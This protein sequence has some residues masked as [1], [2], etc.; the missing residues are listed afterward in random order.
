M[1]TPIGGSGEGGAE[2]PAGPIRVRW[3]ACPDTAGRPGH[4]QGRPSPQHTR[5]M[6]RQRRVAAP[7]ERSAGATIPRGPPRSNPAALRA[8]AGARASRRAGGDHAARPLRS[9]GVDRASIPRPQRRGPR[10][11]RGHVRAGA[12]AG[13]RIAALRAVAGGGARGTTPPMASIRRSTT[14]CAARSWRL[15]RRRIPS[16]AIRFLPNDWGGWLPPGAGGARFRL[17]IPAFV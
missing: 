12:S 3:A 14:G 17:S 15:K 4:C 6:E 7:R 1:T 9:T 16:K 2:R 10:T 13:L 8:A 5:F 11:A